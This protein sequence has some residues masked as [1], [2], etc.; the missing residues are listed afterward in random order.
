MIKYFKYFLL[1]TLFSQY[2][3]QFL[4]TVD[5]NFE[6]DPEINIGRNSINNIALKE[7]EEKTL[8][9]SNENN[10]ESYLSIRSLEN[11][12]FNI[13]SDINKVN[14]NEIDM[15][16]E[17]LTSSD[18]EGKNQ[19]LTISSNYSH[20]IEVIHIVKDKYSEY[21]NIIEEDD[22]DITIKNYNFVKFIDSETNEIKVG[23]KFK[24]TLNKA[25]FHYGIV[26]LSSNCSYLIPQAFNFGEGIEKKGFQNE[27][28]IEKEDIDKIPNPK[29]HLAFIFTL[30]STENF[31]EYEVIIN[32]DIM[33]YFLIGSIIIALIFAVITFFLIRRKQ[34]I[35]NNDFYN[36]DNKE[37]QK[38]EKED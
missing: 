32:K 4:Y 7:N 21:Y 26:S 20:T 37:D 19:I 33:N 12:K 35:K 30:E 9:L 25:N 38:E 24:N 31:E 36:E 8:S 18:F 3:P 10:Q 22:K 5:S 14:K 16:I 23:I 27:I 13:T 28:T 34:N 15:I 1:L 11:K 29:G 6:D 17:N 2:L